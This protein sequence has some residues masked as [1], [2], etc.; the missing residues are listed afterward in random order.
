[1]RDILGRDLPLGEWLDL[2]EGDPAAQDRLLREA[3]RVLDDH[4]RRHGG[5]RV[6]WHGL[7]FVAD[8]GPCTAHGPN[9]PSVLIALAAALERG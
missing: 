1:M 8:L 5:V 7:E 9:L 3:M 6:A 4:A 2:A